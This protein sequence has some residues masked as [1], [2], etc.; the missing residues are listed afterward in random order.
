MLL[1]LSME[2]LQDVPE[3]L[4]CISTLVRQSTELLRTNWS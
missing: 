4:K 3:Y 2:Q 1:I